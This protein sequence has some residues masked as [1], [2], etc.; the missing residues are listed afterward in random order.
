[1][2]IIISQKKQT[3]KY[4]KLLFGL[5][6]TNIRRMSK[7][8]RNFIIAGRHRRWQ[9][10]WQFFFT[11]WGITMIAALVAGAL[12][13][14][15]LL[16]TP[17]SLINMTDVMQNQFKMSGASLSGVDSKGGP[18]QITATSGRLEYNRPDI[19]IFEK[20]SGYTTQLENGQ[21]DVLNFSADGGEYNI[22]TKVLQ[23]T[24]NVNILSKNDGH[25]LQTSELT[26]RLGE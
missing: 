4:K 14:H 20:L 16:W 18:F 25:K 5:R 15:Q 6:W 12:F 1:M 9:R 2:G 11:G 24:G 7:D 17:I 21:K 13:T 23:L 26:I 8:K 10:L 22:K 19:I 3:T